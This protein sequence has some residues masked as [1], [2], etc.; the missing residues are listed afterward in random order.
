MGVFDRSQSDFKQ[1]CRC[2]I[3][4]HQ[5]QL[6]ANTEQPKFVVEAFAH[7]PVPWGADAEGV[8][9]LT[10]C[11]QDLVGLVVDGLGNREVA[12]KLNLSEHTVKN[13]MFRIFDKL[14]ISNRVELVL[15]ALTRSRPSHF[16]ANSTVADRKSESQPRVE[17]N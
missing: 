14:G 11:E 13:Y 15:Y 5:G 8:N 1:L 3:C 10:R 4:V 17:R 6:W 7:A 2:T 16:P 9:L 12:R